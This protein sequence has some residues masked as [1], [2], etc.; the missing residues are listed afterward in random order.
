MLESERDLFVHELGN[1]YALERELEE[2]QSGLADN[3]TD[4]ELESFFMAY[5]EATTEQLERLETIFEGVEAEPD[6][7]YL[8]VFE[9]LRA[10]REATLQFE[11]K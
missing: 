9:G 1:L 2:Y 3:A 11:V 10:D 6:A 5:S 8:E 4:E 7:R